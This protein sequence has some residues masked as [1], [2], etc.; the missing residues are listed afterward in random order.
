MATSEAPS[1]PKPAPAAEQAKVSFWIARIWQGMTLPTWLRL[2]TEHRFRV[3]QPRVTLAARISMFSMFNALLAGAENIGWG[4]QIRRARVAPPVF[5]IGHWRTGTTWLH[6]LLALDERFSYPTT[7]QCM[8]PHH[9]LTSQDWVPWLLPHM[10]PKQ[11]PMDNMRAGWDR[12]QEDEFALCNLG[13]PSPYRLWAFP[14]DPR[15]HDDSLTMRALPAA[16]RTRWTRGL[17]RFVQ[18]LSLSDSRRLVLKSPTHTARVGLLREL[19]PGAQ[20][21]HIVRDPFVVFSSTVNLWKRLWSIMGMQVPHFRNLTDYVFDQFNIMYRQFFADRP[22]LRAGEMCEVRYEDLRKNLLGEMRRV[23]D[24]LGLGGF[25]RV[26]P[27]LRGYIEETKDYRTNKFD[28]EEGLRHDI[29]HQ[30]GEYF[31]Q[32]GYEK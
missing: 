22:Q 20:F 18:H 2:L 27:K 28:L 30:W 3:A 25:D 10:M 5:V 15:R 26:E 21:V 14:N 23:Y 24:E 7:Y 32:Y 12:P 4:V 13:L 31:E 9:F 29:A 19:F 16:E 17:R 6:E 8:A 1:P 11:R